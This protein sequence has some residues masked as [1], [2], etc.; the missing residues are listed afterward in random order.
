MKKIEKLAGNMCDLAYISN[1]PYYKGVAN[2]LQSALNIFYN[3]PNDPV[4]FDAAEGIHLFPMRIAAMN[5]KYDLPVNH[6]PSLP[7]NVMLRLSQFKSIMLKEIGEIDDIM[8]DYNNSDMTGTLTAIAYLLADIT[9]Y[10]RSE[11]VR[12]GIPL[13]EVLQIVM[14]SNDTKLGADGNPIKDEDGK[15]LKG[16]NFEPPEPAIRLLLLERM[17]NDTPHT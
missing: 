1:D 10:C 6:V 8:K 17:V 16:P 15:F 9:V 3:K 13:E 4:P 5:R 14:D 12:Y 2:G 11:A 7:E